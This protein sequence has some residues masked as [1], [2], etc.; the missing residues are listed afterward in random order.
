MTDTIPTLGQLILASGRSY[1][2]LAEASHLS[3]SRIGQMAAD[4]IR[5]LPGVDTIANLAA[6]LGIPADDVEAAAIQTISREHGPILSTA[7]RLAHLDPR[8][9][10]IINAVLRALEE[11]A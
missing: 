10:R 7:R 1:R 4:Q 9:R 2:D 11:E 8:G 3:K 5:Q 6:A